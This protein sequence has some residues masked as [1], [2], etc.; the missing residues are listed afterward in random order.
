MQY[1]STIRTAA[2]LTTEARAAQV[3]VTPGFSLERFLPTRSNPS[4][5]FNFNVNQTALP[6]A[7]AYRAWDVE[8]GFSYTQGTE[9]RSGKLPPISIKH[10]IGEYDELVQQI[11]GPALIQGVFDE[12][13]RGMAA[14]IQTRVE[15]ARGQALETGTVT[16]NEGK[17]GA[18]IDFGRKA[19]HTFTAA[20]LWSDPT[21]DILGQLQSASDL[22]R[23][24]NG[25]PWAEL[26]MSTRVR[27][28]LQRNKGII[29]QALQRTD[30]LPAAISVTDVESVLSAWGFGSITINDEQ[31]QDVNGNNVRVLSDNKVIPVAATGG[32]S[33][34]GNG[35]SGLGSTDFGITAEAVNPTYGIGG[36][37]RSGLFAAAYQGHDPEG[38]YVLVSAVVLPVLSNANGTMTITVL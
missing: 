31:V 21:A 35:A 37:D 4:L 7:A 5:S 10:R 33:L 1:D 30:N 25:G 18:T 11:D 32:I 36:T 13:T 12:R 24:A 2:Q 6:R 38:K 23:I 3:V 16:L 27:S 8:A 28:Y 29:G 15:L 17:L 9:N 20:T 34:T 22:F 26:L 14:Q 19:S